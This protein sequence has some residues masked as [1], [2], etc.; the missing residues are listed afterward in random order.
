MAKFLT[1]IDGLKATFSDRVVTDEIRALSNQQLVLNAGESFVYATGQTNEYVYANAESGLQINSSPDNW[2]SGWAGRNTTT[3][4]DPN[5]NSSFSGDIV[6]NNLSG[7]NT[8]DKFID[9]SDTANAVYTGGRVGIGTTFP[10]SKLEVVGTGWGTE[11][12]TVTSTTTDGAVINLRTTDRHF[13]VSSRSNTFDIRDKTAGDIS[14]FNIKS[15]GNV[16]VGITN[17]N[18]KLEVVGS[19]NDT[20]KNNL[21]LR[22][23]LNASIFS[24]RNDGRVDI[25]N[26]D[27]IV[28]GAVNTPAVNFNSVNPSGATFTRNG[29]YFGRLGT[30][31]NEITLKLEDKNFR[32]RSKTGAILTT[33]N[34]SG[35]TAVNLSGT[36]TGDQDLSGYL[37]N[38]NDLFTGRLRF[39]ATDIS[40]VYN[41]ATIEIREVGLVTNTQ[42]S[43]AYA[44]SMAFHWGGLSSRRLFMTSDGT[45]NW[46]G[47]TPGDSKAAVHF[48]AGRFDGDV[49]IQHA[50]GTPGELLHLLNNTNGS[51]ATIKFS[52]KSDV[53]QYG[54]LSYYHSDG[55]SYGS[56]NAFVLDGTEPTMSLVVKGKVMYSEGIY[57]VPAAGTGAGT[58][59][60][61]N[62]DT[63]FGWGD[64]STQG[65]LTL[66]TDSQTLTWDENTGDLSISNGNTRNLDGRYLLNTTDTLN[67][68]L[69][70]TGTTYLGDTLVMSNPGVGNSSIINFA[71]TNDTAQII[72]TEHLADSTEF[73]FY[74]ADNPSSTNDKFNWYI[75]SWMGD[76]NDWK[77]LEFSG[78]NSTINSSTTTINGDLK[79][80]NIP[81]VS[82]AG[83]KDSIQEN[84]TG[85]LSLSANVSGYTG[86]GV[87]GIYIEL[88]TDGTTFTAGN[89]S[90]G[91][92][93]VQYL[94][95]EPITGSPQL[96]TAGIYITLSGTGGVA[97]DNWRFGVW[98]EGVVNL[99]N[100]TGSQLL[101]LDSSRNIISVAKATAHNKSFGTTSGTVAEGDHLHSDI[102]VSKVAGP[103]AYFASNYLQFNGDNVSNN[104]YI[105]YNDATNAYYLNADTVRQN[106]SANAS[107]YVKDVNANGAIT[108]GAG[109]KMSDDTTAASAANEGTQRYRKDANNSYVDMCMQTGATAY[110]WVNIVQNNW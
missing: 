63:A 77:P 3:I 16:G 93:Y 109:V 71:K 74:M 10:I 61:L 26:G 79:I 68:D 92:S 21:V 50:D 95:N 33:I 43:E 24:V 87:Q 23:S 18:A 14:R 91:S 45:L 20:S 1:N 48:G 7:T 98:P 31:Y 53:A 8:G 106:T 4:N 105:S 94:L 51:G 73:Q 32:F 60:D 34:D 78:Y 99:N 38:T 88:S 57:T 81:Y 12:I 75:S 59:K 86:A 35:I 40:G 52:D 58:R 42:S 44:P 29:V 64:H 108:S 89:K 62:W 83:I 37:L 102:Y 69:T 70:V 55:F 47:G 96:I 54:L 101:E 13:E 67:G 39:N 11:G 17:A 90:P 72:V 65:Y 28:S 36:N 19:T 76:Q 110:E 82:T 6:A 25:P 49:T 97:G 66:E 41:T 9:G 100:L 5:G 84:K 85:T 104:D 30:D 56:A 103:G 107:I 22:D 80:G 2:I 15:D 27:L 46:A